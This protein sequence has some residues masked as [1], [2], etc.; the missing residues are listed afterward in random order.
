MPK[1][2]DFREKVQPAHTKKNPLADQNLEADI[3]ESQVE[4]VD[5]QIALDFEENQPAAKKASSRRRPGMERTSAG[6][7][8]VEHD[9]GVGASSSS[10]DSELHSETKVEPS[11]T[12]SSGGASKDSRHQDFEDEELHKVNLE[13]YGKD[14]VKEK[15]PRVFRSMEIVANDWMN[16]G[17]FEGLPVGHPLMQMVA[18]KSLQKAKEVERKLEEKGV[19]FL[20]KTG[21]ELVKAKVNELKKK[22]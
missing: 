9:A 1:V 22:I 4:E 10:L 6:G 13:F 14:W 19:F 11:F 18:S 2:K 8:S 17:K 16:D 21:V 5:D 15:A 20:A 3:A 12:E 7:K